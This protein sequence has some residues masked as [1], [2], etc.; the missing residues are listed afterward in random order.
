MYGSYSKFYYKRERKKT[1][2]PDKRGKMKDPALNL[3]NMNET[4]HD[5]QGEPLQNRGV[6]S[7]VVRN[8][9]QFLPLFKKNHE[10]YKSRI[11]VMC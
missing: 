2:R 11:S 8:G 4:E 1:E 3:E 9:M 6:S 7:R 5:G 10:S